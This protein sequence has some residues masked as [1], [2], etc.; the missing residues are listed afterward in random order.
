MFHLIRPP[1]SA[2]GG[3]GGQSFWQELVGSPQ[4]LLIKYI[5]VLFHS[6][7]TESGCCPDACWLLLRLCHKEPL[8]SLIEHVSVAA[9]KGIETDMSLFH[10]VDHLSSSQ[11]QLEVG[12]N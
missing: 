10:L 7:Q 3:G 2:F 4:A 5:K 1:L 8:I 11:L 9:G 6:G 12:S